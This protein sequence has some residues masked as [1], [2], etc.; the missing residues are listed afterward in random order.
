MGRMLPDAEFLIT[1]GTPTSADL[2]ARRL[3]P[4]S[5]HQFAPLDAPGPVRRFLRHW[6]PQAAIFVESELWPQ[7][8]MLGHQSGMPL[9]LVNARMSPR[10]V[11]GWRKRPKTAAMVLSSFRLILTQT[12]ELARAMV[13]L[14]ADPAHVRQGVNLKALSEPL[15]IDAEL[16]ET[17]KQHIG[18][19]PVWVA[20]STHPGEE[21]MVLDAHARLLESHPD[22]LLILAPRHPQRGEEVAQVIAARG[23]PTPRRSAGEWPDGPVFLADTLGELGSWYAL[24]H[25][26]FLG[27]SLQPVGGH[28]PYEVAQSGA[29]VLSGP[30]VFNFAETFAAMTR[31]GSTKMVDD[32]DDLAVKAGAWLARLSCLRGRP[33]RGG[34]IPRR[35]GGP[36]RCDGGAIDLGAGPDPCLIFSS[37]I[38][39]A[40]SPAC[41]PRRRT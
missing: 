14:G 18:H 3:P 24:T 11:A 26:V 41:P 35:A 36:A 20:A 13:D 6:S 40:T 9:A 31:T 17:M 23:W 29:A 10:S 19:R 16:V 38:S 2:V 15:P 12:A 1:S 8:L 32:G 7:M 30:H 39:T 4:R 27:G 21:D 22:L 5:R 37:P 28:N 34:R 33:D 25:F